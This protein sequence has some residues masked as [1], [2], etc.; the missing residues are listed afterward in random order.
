[1]SALAQVSQLEIMLRFEISQEHQPYAR[2]ILAQASERVRIAAKQ[3]GWIAQ[4]ETPSLGQSVV[5]Q[6][7]EDIVLWVAKRAYTDPGNLQ[8]RTSG[9]VSETFFENGVRGLELSESELAAL[10]GMAPGGRSTGL[11]VQPVGGGT[12]TDRYIGIRDV[13]VGAESIYFHPIDEG[14]FG[15]VLP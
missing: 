1:M 8:R 3:P 14:A 12:F 5:P 10:G 4:G 7:A 2:M 6:V 15:P 9:P 11:W 13:S